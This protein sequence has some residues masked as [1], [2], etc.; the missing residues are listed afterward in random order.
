MRPQR[1]SLE[2]T[3]NLVEEITPKLDRL[4]EEK[5]AFLQFQKS[6]T[7]L[8]KINRVLRA[9]EWAESQKRVEEKKAEIAAKEKEKDGMNKANAKLAKE[10]AAAEKDVETVKAQREKEMK[11]GGKFKKLE[12]DVGEREKAL[13]K[14]KTQVDIKNGTIADEEGKMIEL[15]RDLQE[16]EDLLTQK[17]TQVEQ[18]TGAQNT[19][20]EKHATLQAALDNSEELLQTLLT[21][22]SSSKDNTTGGGY[23]GQ[24]ADA[25]ARIAQGA[26]EEEQGRVKLS[27]AEKDL[28]GLEARWKDVEREASEGKRQLSTAKANVEKMKQKVAESGWSSEKDEQVERELQTTRNSVRRLR[29]ERDNIKQRLP[30][31]N[32]DYSSP[33]P[34][35]DRSKVKGLVASLVHLERDD[36]NKSTALEIA[37]GGR[38]YNVVVDNPQVGSELLQ[39]GRLKK[40]VTIIPLTQIEAHMIS[41]QT[42]LSKNRNASETVRLAL[43]I[44]GYDQEVTSAMNFVFGG[45]LICDDA[46]TAKAVTFNRAVGASSGILVRVQELL[47]AER[48]LGEAQGTLATLER[49]YE[50]SREGRERWRKLSKELD[51]KEHEMRLLEERVGGSNAARIG[52]EIESAKKSIADLKQ[53]VQNAKEKQVQAKADCKKLEKDM[54]EFKNNKEGKIDELK[55]NVSKQKAALQKHAVVVKTQQKDVQTATLELDQLSEDIETARHGI[56][57]AR[58]GIQKLHKELGKLKDQLAVD[59]AAFRKAEAKLQEERA[60]L[61]RFDDELKELES[62]I[63]DKK[64]ASGDNELSLQNLDHAIQNLAKEKTAALNVVNG[65]EKTNGWILE[66][67][68]SFGRRGSQYD[69]SNFDIGNL[70]ERAQTLEDQQQGMQKKVNNQAVNLADTAEKKEA[71]VK[72][73]LSRVLKDR[74]KIEQTIEEL[75]R[76]KREALERTWSKVN[77]DFGAIFAELLPG[78]FAKLQPPEGQDL[79]QGLEVKVQ[80]GTV[81]KQSL[82]ELSGGQRSLIALSLIMALLQ[83]KPAPMYILDE[84]DAALDLSHTQHIGQLF[85]TR[86][87]GS[88]F[89][90]VSLKEGLFTNANV[91][92]RTKFRDGTSIVERTAQRSTSALYD[93]ASAPGPRRRG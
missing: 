39:N 24:L 46:D 17:R 79:T 45:T 50:R 62:V 49:E 89:I 23:L 61:T 69:F 14:I 93:N 76:H 85:R 68:E 73:M 10:V 40:R 19:I 27:M 51:I 33:S 47:D 90:V 58:A 8:E 1:N 3:A 48:K 59:E 5:R 20:K 22:L 81:W 13:V 31:L 74:E 28:K 15:E 80:L 56:S 18:L 63:K 83:F 11:K 71:G 44:V 37:A 52:T 21:G 66:E 29:E 32:F 55:T 65:L 7:E 91:L 60:T 2:L 72:D 16:A 92:F 70:R 75:D 64:A 57:E 67:K 9:W 88:Q 38:L 26:A 12:E 77:G 87:K 42:A 6:R 41:P 43:E 84:I 30:Q 36:Y 53:A 54:A 34:N 35:F 25:K 4:R 78:N 82:T 86:F